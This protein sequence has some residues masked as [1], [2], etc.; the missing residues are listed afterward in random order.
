[1]CMI[2]QFIKL[3]NMICLSVSWQNTKLTWNGNKLFREMSRRGKNVQSQVR[4]FVVTIENDSFVAL[5]KP[6]VSVTSA[7]H[8]SRTLRSYGVKLMI[9]SSS[10]DASIHYFKIC[11]IFGSIPLRHLRQWKKTNE[12][13]SVTHKRLL[14]VLTRIFM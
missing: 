9:S 1:M 13:V 11:V 5:V 14:I 2:C 7:L 10:A 12:R 4:T 6:T 3:C 8:A